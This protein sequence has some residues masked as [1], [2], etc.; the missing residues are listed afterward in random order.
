MSNN[1]SFNQDNGLDTMHPHRKRPA[2]V[3]QL[4]LFVKYDSPFTQP[5]Q[6]RFVPMTV[7]WMKTAGPEAIHGTG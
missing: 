7:D 4:P 6:D 5:R 3:G 2:F 1:E